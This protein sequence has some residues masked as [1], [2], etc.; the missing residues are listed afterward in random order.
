M[1]TK[2]KYS[3]I[4]CKLTQKII[5]YKNYNYRNLWRISKQWT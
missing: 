1:I 2:T 3:T 5:N 4:Q